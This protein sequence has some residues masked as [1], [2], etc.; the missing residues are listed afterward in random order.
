VIFWGWNF[1]G[2]FGVIFWNF[3]FENFGGA[4][5][6]GKLVSSSYQ[7]ANAD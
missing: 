5:G 7:L 6:W 2:N 1:G 3:I 4:R